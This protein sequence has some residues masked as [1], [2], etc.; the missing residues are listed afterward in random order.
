MI[1]R[2]KINGFKSLVRNEIYF[3][4]FTCIAGDNAIGKSNFFDALSFLSNLADKTIIKAAKSVRSESQ[5][6][7]NIHDIFFRSGTDLMQTM[8]FEIDM[9]VPQL[10]VDD[11][12][13]TAEATITS[14]RYKLELKIN[15]EPE[16]HEPVSIEHEELIPKEPPKSG[17]NWKLNYWEKQFV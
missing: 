14:L 11:L 15:E 9:L 3:G 10:G 4:S 16:N 6:H 8:S 13:Q 7:S 1:T 5:K 2:V 12:G 17:K